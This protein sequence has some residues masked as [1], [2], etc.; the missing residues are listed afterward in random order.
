[1]GVERGSARFL[2]FAALSRSDL[3]AMC[4]RDL[5]LVKRS[6]CVSELYYRCAGCTFDIA[7]ELRIQRGTFQKLQE[8]SPGHELTTQRANRYQVCNRVTVHGNPHAF[9]RDQNLK[10]KAKRRLS[11]RR[12]R[13]YNPTRVSTWRSKYYVN[14]L[15]T[16]RSTSS[17]TRGQGLC[18]RM[19][20]WRAGGATTWC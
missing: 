8:F 3:P 10:Q 5:R 7:L 11:Q 4:A 17:R 13:H 15:G 6:D 1:V 12:T 18:D 19:N 9:A 14:R 20:S 16:E 2:Y